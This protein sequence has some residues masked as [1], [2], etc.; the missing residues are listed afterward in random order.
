[1]RLYQ[2]ARTNDVLDLR[3]REPTRVGMSVD[4]AGALSLVDAV[5]LV[6]RAIAEMPG[7]GFA[8]FSDVNVGSRRDLPQLFGGHIVG[9]EDV[10][11]DDESRHDAISISE[12]FGNDAG[13][14]WGGGAAS[15]PLSHCGTARTLRDDHG[16]V[17]RLHGLEQCD[18][19]AAVDLRAM[20]CHIHS[21][22]EPLGETKDRLVAGIEEEGHGF[23]PACE[24]RRDGVTYQAL[25]QPVAAVRSIHGNGQLHPT[26]WPDCRMCLGEAHDMAARV[27]YRPNE[28]GPRCDNPPGIRNDHLVAADDTEAGMPI[29][30]I[31]R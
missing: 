25:T 16:R 15:V 30:S 24:R 11:L 21:Y 26:R 23:S 10:P 3:H 14:S 12:F 1:L 20:L 13:S 9:S 5:E 4:R 27:V 19:V 29:H 2:A 7:T 28:Y 6:A 8:D 18:R 17:A 31:E 22:P